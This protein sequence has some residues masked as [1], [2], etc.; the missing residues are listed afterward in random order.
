VVFVFVGEGAEKKMLMEKADR[1]KLTNVRFL[2]GQPKHV[3]ASWYAAADAVLVPLRNIPLFETF[4]PSKMFEI[5]ACGRPIVGSVRGE[6]RAI[7][8]ASQGALV[9][10]PEDSSAIASAIQT[11][12]QSPELAERLGR[13]GHRFVRE[14]YDRR[15]L[16]RQ[17]L[18]LLSGMVEGRR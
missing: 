9:V 4:I 18:D 3:M 14:H 17:Y 8:E 10:D 5:M 1:M 6:A 2:P 16:A 12:R 7:L 15:A 11:L 13:A